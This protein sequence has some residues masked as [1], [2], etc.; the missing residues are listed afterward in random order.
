MD[1]DC[2][3]S[4]YACVE[5]SKVFSSPRIKTTIFVSRFGNATSVLS[6]TMTTT[7]END[8]PSL[9]GNC[10]CAA[11]KFSVQ[12]QSSPGVP[13]ALFSC[14]CPLCSLNACIWAQPF[15]LQVLRGDVSL[16]KG[17]RNGTTLHK[18]CSTCG[19]S[20]LCC[21]AEEPPRVLFVNV[22]AL[23]D[24]DSS[25]PVISSS[26]RKDAPPDA[27]ATLETSDHYRGSCCCGGISYTLR[28][29]PIDKTKSCNC[30]ICSRNGVLWTYPP[31]SAFAIA[32]GV[33]LA[34]YTFGR[35]QVVHAFCST[36]AVPVWERFLLPAKAAS[37]G[38]NVRTIH[39]LD[40][41][42]L[43]SRVHNGVATLPKYEVG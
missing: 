39:G 34:E 20:L 25:W 22:R 35:K 23:A 27:L 30:S 37:M 17:Y 10:H 33:S 11:F 13:N 16:L 15:A 18:F 3:Q 7:S 1:V 8:S 36:C 14:G 24:F 43:P 6:R 41:R 19:T 42:D 29:P 5:Q 9:P 12:L 32:S 2:T 40:Y 26:C 21:D 4:C 31:V 28:I 38:V